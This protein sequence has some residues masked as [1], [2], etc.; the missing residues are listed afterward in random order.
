METARTYLLSF[1]LLI[2]AQ[3]YADP[4]SKLALD[5][6][7]VEFGNGGCCFVLC[8]ELDKP[9][10]TRTGQKSESHRIFHNYYVS[11]V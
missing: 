8:F 2:S 10:D 9:R 11:G 1:R 3:G 6:E 5:R 7:V 4:Q